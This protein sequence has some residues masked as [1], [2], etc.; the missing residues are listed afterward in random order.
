MAKNKIFLFGL[1]N[2]GK[3][4]LSEYIREDKLL[5]D[6][7]P[8]KS[9]NINGMIL[10]NLEFIIW[11]APG[12][13]QYRKKWSKGILDTNILMF[14]LDTADEERL[15][16]AK[17]ELYR[18]INDLDTRGAPLI[19]CFHKMDLE[20]AESNLEKAKGT[21]KM[22]QINEREGYWFRTSVKTGEG[23]EPLKEKLVDLVEKA[24]WG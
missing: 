10:K 19:V 5:D 18:V 22:S 20:E 23:I 6:P 14:V 15:E 24:R 16:E 1:D 13:T 17:K 12:Q 7:K 21:L 9:F 4:T 3:T 11:D 8:T 2:A